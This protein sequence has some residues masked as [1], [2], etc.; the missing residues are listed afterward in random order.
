MVRWSSLVIST[1]GLI[2]GSIFLFQK[3]NG[4]TAIH[5]VFIIVTITLAQGLMYWVGSKTLD[6][7]FQ[8]PIHNVDRIINMMG[9]AYSDI[10]SE[11]TA[12]VDGEEW[13]A[14]SEIFISAESEI[15]VISRD[16][17]IL[18]VEAVKSSNS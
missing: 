11:G 16:G 17:L 13:S 18:T 5:P 1:L 7:T 4:E 6:A 2:L 12:Y 10:F 8:K 3:V 14:R 15:K 9:T